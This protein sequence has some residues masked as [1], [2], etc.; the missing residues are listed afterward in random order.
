LTGGVDDIWGA[1]VVVRFGLITMLQSVRTP[2]GLH[3]SSHKPI[4]LEDKVKL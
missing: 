2:E 3:F 4:H 1:A